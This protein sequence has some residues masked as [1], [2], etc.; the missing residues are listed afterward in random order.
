MKKKYGVL[1]VVI[2]L[3]SIGLA[4]GWAK[5]MLQVPAD[6]GN[7]RVTS[8]AVVRPALRPG[9]RTSVHVSIGDNAHGAVTYA[10]KA[11]AGTLS[12]SDTNPVIW[13]APASE[14]HYQVGVEVINAA[15][16]KCR[17]SAGVLV[18]RHPA[19]QLVTSVDPMGG[20][21]CSTDVA[22]SSSQ[23]SSCD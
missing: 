18:S 8:F 20:K 9:E 6:P 1:L 16:S 5:T 15:G 11:D 4:G 14:G 19:A 3:V 10:W 2:W 7:I 21:Q 12:A 13:T 17:G 22:G 23:T